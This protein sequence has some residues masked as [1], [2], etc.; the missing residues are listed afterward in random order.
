MF[1]DFIT[2]LIKT[3]QRQIPRLYK[4]FSKCSGTLLWAQKCYSTHDKFI[5]LNVIHL[6]LLLHIIV[7]IQYLAIE[8]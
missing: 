4:H 5:S 8:L 3:G 7:I 6:P 2:T 1:F